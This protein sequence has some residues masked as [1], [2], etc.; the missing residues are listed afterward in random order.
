LVIEDN[1]APKVRPDNSP[2]LQRRETAPQ[3]PR[4]PKGRQNCPSVPPLRLKPLIRRRLVGV[5]LAQLQVFTVAVH[6][7][8]VAAVKMAIAGRAVFVIVQGE[9]GAVTPK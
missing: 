3:H 6:E 8:E 4:V 1:N 7:T 2:A 9:P 5:K